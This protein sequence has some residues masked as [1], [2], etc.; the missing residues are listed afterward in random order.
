M[1]MQSRMQL[2]FSL[3]ELMVAMAIGIFLMFGAV[4]VFTNSKRT[5]NENEISSRL[6]ENLRFAS[7]ILTHDVRMAGYYGCAN[8]DVPT[9]AA[10]PTKLHS[11]IPAALITNAN[12]I[13]DLTG[14][15]IE[16]WEGSTATAEWLPS[17]LDI[18]AWITAP[19]AS[20]TAMSAATFGAPIS[21]GSPDAILIRHAGG[22]HWEV[23]A[24]MANLTSAVSIDNTPVNGVA[25]NTGDL[26]SV[27]NCNSADVFRV[28][29]QGSTSVT[30]V[31]GTKVNTE[32]GEKKTFT[33]DA[34]TTVEYATSRLSKFA[35][36]AYYIGLGC[37]D[38]D[39]DSDTATC[40][41]TGPALF[42]QIWDSSSGS[43]IRQQLLA[44]IENMQI[45][46]GIDT[47]GDRVPDAYVRA[48][49][50]SLGT[51]ANWDS[52]VVSV[53]IGLLAR[54]ELPR[55]LQPDTRVYTL[56]DTDLFGGAAPN[57]TH[58]RRLLVATV[59]L[60]NTNQR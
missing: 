5:Y 35:P 16:G 60:R 12:H 6:Q 1:T 24:Q 29:S 3:V 37:M 8:T 18:S 32:Y 49:D 11:A 51:A 59:A 15:G 9:T 4:T 46:Y 57:D 40:A 26:V 25:V 31:S 45:T 42:R 33:S 23:T 14:G 19:V 50:A 55:S 28:A 56:N 39:T 30:P 53:R 54:T 20:D 10:S 2:G 13:L 41:N 58:T 21:T 7:E 38:P 36:V 17:G 27:S 44:G 43:V 48:D 47:S 22:V 52:Q 34:G